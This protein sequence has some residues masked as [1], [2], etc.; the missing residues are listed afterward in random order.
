MF[1]QGIELVEQEGVAWRDICHEQ[2]LVP[3]IL[4]EGILDLAH[5]VQ[6]VRKVRSGGEEQRK[7]GSRKEREEESR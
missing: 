7:K 4:R 3:R 1:A 5:A 2:P 6:E